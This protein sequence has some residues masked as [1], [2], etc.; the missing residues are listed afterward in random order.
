MTRDATEIQ[1]DIDTLEEFADPYRFYFGAPDVKGDVPAEFVGNRTTLRQLIHRQ[2]GPVERIMQAAGT[3]GIGV[4]PPPAIGGP[5]R[6]G[7]A[8]TAFAEEH[9]QFQGIE[10]PIYMSVLDSVNLTIGILEDELKK[11]G[12]R[13]DAP[14]PA[15]APP[16]PI[17][18]VTQAAQHRTTGHRFPRLILGRVLTRVPKWLSVIERVVL[19]LAAVAGIVGVLGLIFGWWSNA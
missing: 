16:P 6:H 14:E 17:S 12:K 7:L 9:V 11:S 19:F 5:G 15:S 4:M 8:A 2:L 13:G 1:S 3:N 10:P 18:S